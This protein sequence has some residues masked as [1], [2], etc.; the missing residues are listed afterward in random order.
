MMIFG[1]NGK[2]YTAKEFDYNFVCDI[3]DMGIDIDNCMSNPF[4]MCRVYLALCGS[5][6]LEQAGK[7]LEKH[8]LSGKD[9]SELQ[10]IITKKMEESDFFLHITGVAQKKLEEKIAEEK[11]IEKKTTKK[12]T[13]KTAE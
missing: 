6:T 2:S 8:I 13:K 3:S 12:T 5:I 1:I 10:D 11:V 4:S 7:E 9:L